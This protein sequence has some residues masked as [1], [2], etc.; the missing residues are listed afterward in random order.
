MIGLRHLGKPHQ[1]VR[2]AS[3]QGRRDGVVSLRTAHLRPGRYDVVLRD[4]ATGRAEATAPVWVYRPSSRSRIRSDRH[5]YRVGQPIRIHWTRAPGNNLDWV[6]LFPCHRVCGGVS[7]YLDYLYTH[8]RVVGSVTFRK[9]A[10]L[11]EGTEPWPL[12]PGQYIARV[13][14]DDGY[15]SI[16]RSPRFRVVR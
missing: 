14:L 4:S 1:L 2:Q 16:G 9:G 13:L 10:Y 6:G 12:P 11:G 15:A 7:T 8:T 3:T 5:I